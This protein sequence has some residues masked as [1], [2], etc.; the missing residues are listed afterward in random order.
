M[1]KSRDQGISSPIG[2]AADKGSIAL[3]GSHEVYIDVIS[4]S[5]KDT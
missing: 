5:R 1:R 4:I 3:Y 2:Y